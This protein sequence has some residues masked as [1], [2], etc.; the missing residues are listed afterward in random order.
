MPV[1]TCAE[2][3]RVC[4]YN[5]LPPS[6][7]SG[8]LCAAAADCAKGPQVE[9]VS[10][11]RVRSL[12]KFNPA[13]RRI[14]PPEQELS[15]LLG[16]SLAFPC[17]T[18]GAAAPRR[19]RLHHRHRH[20]MVR[21]LSLQ[22]RHRPRLRQAVL[23]EFGPL[24]RNARGLRHLCGGLRGAAGGRCDLRP[25]WRPHRPQ[26]DPDRDAAAHGSRHFRGGA[27]ADL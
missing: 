8:E 4:T 18:S 20:R 16:S 27:G 1:R 3:A 9:W 7:F 12:P 23:P 22:H 21:F 2:R 25:L 24:G 15:H 17:Q 11:R 5:G 6:K 26:I 10:N 13:D 14:Y 19:D